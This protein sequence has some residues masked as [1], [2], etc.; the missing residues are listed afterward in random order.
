M[1]ITGGV[2]YEIMRK[3]EGW[4]PPRGIQQAETSYFEVCPYKRLGGGGEM[5]SREARRGLLKLWL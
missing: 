1:E 5:F 3:F 2:D 4:A